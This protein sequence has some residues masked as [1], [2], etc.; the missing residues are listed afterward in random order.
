MHLGK[1]ISGLV[2]F[3]NLG[4]D[5][6]I[7]KQNL[8]R[9]LS[10]TLWGTLLLEEL[11]FVRRADEPTPADDFLTAVK[12]VNLAPMIAWTAAATAVEVGVQGFLKWDD[13][14]RRGLSID[15]SHA[16]AEEE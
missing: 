15:A 10:R 5:T 9:V 2:G 12:T 4:R 16:E 7:I 3:D 14:S 6:V 13:W 1:N 11:E 8:K